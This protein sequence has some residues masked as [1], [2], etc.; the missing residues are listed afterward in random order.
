MMVTALIMRP[1]I[2]QMKA[3]AM[4]TRILADDLQLVSVGPKQLENFVAAFN[5]PYEHLEA[6]GANVAA[7]KSL[8]SSSD[9][10]ARRWLTKHGWRRLGKT[11]PVIVDTRD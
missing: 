4:H 3:S 6:M 1:W 7:N 10:V 8:T 2:M 11:I 9:E 5:Q